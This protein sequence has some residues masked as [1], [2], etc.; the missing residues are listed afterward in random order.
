ANLRTTALDLDHGWITYPRPK[1]GIARRCALWPETVEAIRK[2]MSD[3][4]GD[5]LVFRTMFGRPWTGSETDSPI[6]KEFRKLL[7]RLDINGHRGFS[8]L[9]NTNRTIADGAK[10]QPA[11][12]AIMAHQS[13]HMSSHYREAIADDRLRAVSNYVRDWLFGDRVGDP[14]TKI[15]V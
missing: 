12:D 5:N 2:A 8:T 6:S 1:T 9:R 3:R 4:A 15:R 10:D 7:D 13:P 11:A 14:S